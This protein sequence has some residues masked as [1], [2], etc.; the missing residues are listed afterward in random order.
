MEIHFEELPE[1]SPSLQLEELIPDEATCIAVKVNMDS[2]DPSDNN[3]HPPALGAILRYLK[4]SGVE[5]LAA[6]S[7]VHTEGRHQIP[8]VHYHFVCNQY[9]KPSNPSQHRD[10]WLAKA[11]NETEDFEGATF[12]YARLEK[13][14]PKF[15]FLSYPLKEG[16]YYKYHYKRSQLLG[17]D[18]MPKEMFNFLLEVGKTIY[19]TQLALRLRQEKCQERKQL[20]LSELFDLVKDKEFPTF[21]AMMIWL[22]DNYISTLALD[23]LS[24]PKNY[25]TNCQ[26][27]GCKLGLWKY[28]DF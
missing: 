21:R 17:A 16:K 22:E 25:K 4:A 12:K 24:D 9:N 27:I 3:A 1:L 20:A 18:P 15:Q 11:G 8:H 5:I 2:Y 10:R 26:K 14:K 6:T 7:G 19:D 28:S 13:G 23:E